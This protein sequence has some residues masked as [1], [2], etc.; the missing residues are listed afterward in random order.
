LP[1]NRRVVDGPD[2]VRWPLLVILSLTT[3]L[4]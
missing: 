2:N 4:E 3:F 1:A